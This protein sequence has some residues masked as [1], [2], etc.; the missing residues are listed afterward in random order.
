MT[1]QKA[2]IIQVI[3]SEPR[4]Y[5]PDEIFNH[6]KEILPNISR[7]TVY[8][9]L[10]ALENDKV[11]RKISGD[12]G[13]DYYDRSYIPHGHLF[14]EKCKQIC[15]LETDSLHSDLEKQFGCVVDA[16]ELKVRG[17]CKECLKV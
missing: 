8:N 17:I 6:A 2:A 1:R 13:S 3:M 11:I 15:D 12:G 9:N 10:K 16:Y 14:C 4:H 7:A 5:T